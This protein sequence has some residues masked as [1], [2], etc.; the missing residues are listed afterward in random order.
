MGDAEPR[1]GRI[2]FGELTLDLSTGELES[3]GARVQLQE[4]VFRILE[5]LT[6]HPGELVG[7]ER[8]IARIWPRAT[9]IDTD[10]G[11]NTAIKKLRVAIGD[12][13]DAPR[14]VETVPRRGYRFIAPV[15]PAP[16]DVDASRPWGRYALLCAIV[17]LI[18][19][20]LVWV[21]PRFPVVRPD[22][23]IA[24][25]TPAVELPE[26]NVAV[27]PFVNLTGD[28]GRDHL[29]LGL[30]DTLLH[31][32]ADAR[33]INVI[34]RTSSFAFKGR[35]EDVRGIGRKLNARYLVEGSVQDSSNRLRITAQLIDA[36]TGTHVW[37]KAF[38]R[39][40]GD[41]FAVQ[42]DITLEIA[43][44]LRLS[45]SDRGPRSLRP[46]G[47]TSFDAWLAFEQ[48]RA[49]MA[50]RRTGDLHAAVA[51]F[52]LAIR[53]DPQ[54]VAALVE[55]AHAYMNEAN[56][57]SRGTVPSTTAIHE[58]ARRAAPLIDR[59]LAL[60]PASGEAL[61]ARGF[62]AQV[63][64]DT[65]S[66]AADFRRGLELSPN[67]AR[68]HQL[69]GQLLINDLGEPGE[70]L[71]EIERARVLDPLEPRGPYYAGL[72]ALLRGN[73]AQGERL[74]LETLRIR[75]DFAPALARLGWSNWRRGGRFADAIKY[76]EQALR[77]DPDPEWM[78]ALLGREYLELG[79]V[80]AAASLLATEHPERTLA[81]DVHFFRREY[82]RAAELVYAAPEQFGACDEDAYLLLAGAN[83]AAAVDRARRFLDARVALW[84]S[85]GHARVAPGEEP[86]AVVMARLLESSGERARARQLLDALLAGPAAR[87]ASNS[88][89]CFNAGAARARALA[90]LGRRAEAIA[91]LTRVTLD[92]Q[93]WGLGWYTFERDPWFATLQK[94]PGFAALRDAYR[95]RV[96]AERTRLAELRAKGV[97][98]RRPSPT[99]LP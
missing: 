61:V 17:L 62:V 20:L 4:Q 88:V 78:H 91:A 18:G 64:G 89:P 67:Y 2:R 82:Q 51:S 68:G 75:P 65:A 81:M 96:A 14:Y 80:L 46:I 33:E 40:P 43:R 77:I 30:S 35:D 60:D 23:R 54:F 84:D 59:A 36:A 73:T 76:G 55:L 97:I 58:A 29:A 52:E 66:A 45:V 16:V 86:V 94:E 93:A 6:A 63:G 53:L 13:A 24:G 21:V 7:R 3:G 25:S 79:E 28:P 1:T 71:A 19:L 42:D 92:Q 22:T 15:Y 26:H 5:L 31:R 44:A 38:D 8:L 90:A 98:P 32:L 50:S 27:L 83:T 34:A 41:F 99:A 10:A 39:Q 69:Y 11:L 47:T 87:A 9:Y 37:S 95:T 48:G 12:D 57:A 49:S 74:M 56:F 70:G 85:Q 72:A